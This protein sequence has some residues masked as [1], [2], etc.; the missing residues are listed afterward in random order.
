MTGQMMTATWIAKANVRFPVTLFVVA[1]LLLCGCKRI[2]ERPMAA[3]LLLKGEEEEPVS[4]AHGLSP[5][6]TADNGAGGAVD[7]ERAVSFDSVVFLHLHCDLN[8]C[9]GDVQKL[10]SCQMAAS[11]LL[12]ARRRN[13]C[14][15]GCRW[16]R[17]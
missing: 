15:P 9:G 6:V 8:F 11:R 16:R 14:L 7:C 4:P 2:V 3:A 10:A 13:R 12:S 17:R 1:L 5:A